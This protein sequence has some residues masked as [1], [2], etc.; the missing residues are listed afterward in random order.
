MRCSDD[1]ANFDVTIDKEMFSFT[2]VNGGSLM[3]YHLTDSRIFKVKAEY[4]DEFGLP[5][6]KVASFAEDTL[7]LDGFNSVHENVPVRVS[8]LDRN[9]LESE[10]LE[11]TFSTRQ[12]VL[13][14]FFDNVKIGS[15][16]NGF[17]VSYN[18]QGRAEGSASV[19]FLGMNPTTK[20]RDTI[21]LENFV[22]ATGQNMKAYPLDDSQL[23]DSYTVVITTEDNRQ[24]I[25][26]KQVWTGIEGASRLLI[27]STNFELI[28]PFG[29]SWEQDRMTES[30]YYPGATSWKYLFDGDLMGQR[31]MEFVRN[32]Y[33]TPPFTFLTK[34]DALWTETNNVYFVLDMKEDVTVGEM[35]LYMK[36][37]DNYPR[38]WDFDNDYYTKL[39]CNVKVYGWIGNGDYDKEVNPGTEEDWVLLGKFEDDPSIAMEKRWYTDDTGQPL[40]NGLDEATDFSTL[41]P[42]YM[43][44]P[45][46]LEGNGYR[47]LKLRFDA[48][49]VHLTNPTYNHNN[50]NR[51]T[52]HELEIYGIKR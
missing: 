37:T 49:Y 12:S 36:G 6:S 20:M 52:F 42:V 24:R 4:V 28:D 31:G 25:V 14:S 44:I 7:V 23:Q 43:S 13:F 46:E 16:W 35:R 47:F 9:N 39:P 40:L 22:L 30:F 3:R 15:Y 19:F 38:N 17:S 1:D 18:V 26:R 11:F 48:T 32:Y 2:P 27:P 41:T 21:F 8:F 50:N 29:K 5:V 10:V 51:V 45:F 34:P 33:A